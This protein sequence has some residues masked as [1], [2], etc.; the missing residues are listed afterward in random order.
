MSLTT[1]RAISVISSRSTTDTPLMVLNSWPRPS[2]AITILF[3]VQSVS[4]PSRVLIW[5]SSAMPSLMSFSMKA[6]RMASEIW[7]ETLS[8]WPSDTDS[9]VKRKLARDTCTLLRWRQGSRPPY[10]GFFMR[11]TAA[12]S[13]CGMMWASVPVAAGGGQ[14]YRL[15]L[16]VGGDL[17]DQVDDLAPELGVL[18]AHEGLG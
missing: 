10:K 17:L 13:R 3:V 5:L 6:S 4:Q 14:T 15:P 12:R 7:S 8:G 18:D 9:L 1:P 16:V 11:R 2:P